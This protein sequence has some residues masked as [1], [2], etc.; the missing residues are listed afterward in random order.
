VLASKFSVLVVFWSF[1]TAFHL[2]LVGGF[3]RCFFHSVGKTHRKKT[4]LASA[5]KATQWTASLWI[6][7]CRSITEDNA[8]YTVNACVHC[9]TTN[10]MRLYMT[11]L[12]VRVTDCLASELAQVAKE[13]ERPKSFIIQKALEAYL[14]DYADLQIALDR[15]RDTSDSVVSSK[16]MRASLGL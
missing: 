4:P 12:S 11:T 3:I 15:L 7:R 2:V 8:G 1:F 9:N 6:K 5:E 10:Y 16:E 14:E 13:S